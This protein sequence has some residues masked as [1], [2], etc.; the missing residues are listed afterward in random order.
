MEDVSYVQD[1][2]FSMEA[3]YDLD[4]TSRKKGVNHDL[5]ET[6]FSMAEVCSRPI[7]EKALVSLWASSTTALAASPVGLYLKSLLFSL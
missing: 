3:S 7:S 2:F 5:Y 6:P 4:K 1:S